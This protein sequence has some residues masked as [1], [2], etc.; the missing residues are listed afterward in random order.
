MVWSRLVSLNELCLTYDASPGAFTVII[1]VFSFSCFSTFSLPQSSSL[2]M[3]SVMEVV[4]DALISSLSSS[5][6]SAD[7]I[8]ETVLPTR[9]RCLLLLVT[10]LSLA[11]LFLTQV[12][13]SQ[14]QLSLLRAVHDLLG[15]VTT[16]QPLPLLPSLL[17]ALRTMYTVGL[18]GH[19][20]AKTAPP[21]IPHPHKSRLRI[22]SNA[23]Y[24][25]LSVHV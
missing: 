23:C 4:V 9:V 7:D 3:S 16:L 1:S 12:S 22:I 13:L 25:S 2:Q 10:L 14:L 5:I 6:A 20:H 8:S 17:S 21:I 11:V 18:P 15:H 24:C 19:Q